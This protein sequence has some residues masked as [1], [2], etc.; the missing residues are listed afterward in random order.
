METENVQVQDSNGAEEVTLEVTDETTNEGESQ[1]YEA[2]FKA[3]REARLKAEEVARNQKIR[4]EKAE[5]LAKPT[6]K[7]EV[8]QDS[9]PSSISTRDLLAL[10]KANLHE[11]DIPEVEE[12]AK[13]KKISLADALKSSVVKT[14]IGEKEEMRK[15][16]N[17]ANTSN[18]RR[19]QSKPT[20][21]DLIAKAQKGDSVD[22]FDA[23]AQAR[24]EARKNAL[25]K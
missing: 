9:N 10:S 25:K 11:D 2:K 24:M 15:T 19:G 13:F 8:K 22:D 6:S 16:A 18:A 20:G 5:K 4:A 21:S 14:L 12:Y 7:E 17:A 3:E 23:L 1:D